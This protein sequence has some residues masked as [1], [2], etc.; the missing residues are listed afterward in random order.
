MWP[1][2]PAPLPCHP[3]PPPA[4]LSYTHTRTS[5]PFQKN[6]HRNPEPK[7]VSKVKWRWVAKK[8]VVLAEISLKHSFIPNRVH[9][10]ILLSHSFT[11]KLTNKHD[12]FC[13]SFSVK[14]EI[15]GQVSWNRD[16]GIKCW[17]CQIRPEKNWNCRH[18]ASPRPAVSIFSGRTDSFNI[19]AKS[20]FHETTQKFNFDT[21][22]DTKNCHVYCQFQVKLTKK[23]KEPGFHLKPPKF[24][25][26]SQHF[27]KTTHNSNN[28]QWNPAY[29]EFRPKNS[30]FWNLKPS[31]KKKISP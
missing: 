29:G 10:F 24:Q 21:E 25:I 7:K 15:F 11:W 1:L 26:F 31:H 3:Q 18:A 30:F 16:I 22:T 17:N 20:R 9:F 6:Y 8:Y 14:V 2:P 28:N 13:D 4:P 19:L 12:S 23:K 5:T 27:S